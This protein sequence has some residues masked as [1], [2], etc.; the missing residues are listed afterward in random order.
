MRL[1]SFILFR[2]LGDRGGLICAAG[3]SVLLILRL[4]G[5]DE[6]DEL[7]DVEGGAAEV[8]RAL[9]RHDTAHFGQRLICQDE[10]AQDRLV[11]AADLLVAGSAKH[12][13]DAAEGACLLFEAE[14]NAVASLDLFVLVLFDLVEEVL[15]LLLDVIDLLVPDLDAVNDAILL[16]LH[17]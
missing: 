8:H 15:A 7:E 1:R 10:R 4:H 9:G 13:S 14:L 16:Q 2:S 6:L 12:A 5:V 3:A 11:A 17:G